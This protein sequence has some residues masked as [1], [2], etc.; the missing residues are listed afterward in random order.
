M[1]KVWVVVIVLF[2]AT[3][4]SINLSLALSPLPPLQCSLEGTIK[5][6]E[7]AEAGCSGSPE[8]SEICWV[9]EYRLELEVEGVST[10]ECE[11]AYPLKSIQEIIVN[12]EEVNEGDVFEVNSKIS[13]LTFRRFGTY[14]TSYR[15]GLFELD[16]SPILYDNILFFGGIIVGVIVL[17]IIIVFVIYKFVKKRNRLPP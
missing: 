7:F 10:G 13:G 5:N 1:K 15:L 12:K 11:S 16:A 3:V 4:L 9:D 6:V 17:I 14:F 8:F 2:L